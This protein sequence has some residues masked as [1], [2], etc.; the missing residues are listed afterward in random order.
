MIGSRFPQNRSR[1]SSTRGIALVSILLLIAMISALVVL[2]LR[3]TN[4]KRW[5]AGRDRSQA[6]L[7]LLAR[8]ATEIIHLRLKQR[9]NPGMYRDDGTSKSIEELRRM[10]EFSDEGTDALDYCPPD[11]PGNCFHGYRFQQGKD[12]KT[13]LG[14]YVRD[15]LKEASHT[16][17]GVPDPVG[18]FEPCLESN[19]CAANEN[20]QWKVRYIGDHDLDPLYPATGH[21]VPIPLHAGFDFRNDGQDDEAYQLLVE[22]EAFDGK[23]GTRSVIQ[24]DYL[25]VAPFPSVDAMFSSSANV[26]SPMNFHS[27]YVKG[28]LGHFPDSRNLMDFYSGKPWVDL[29][30]FDFGEKGVLHPACKEYGHN[31]MTGG[32]AKYPCNSLF[33]SG[34]R[35]AD[36]ERPIFYAHM[37][38]KG[39]ITNLGIGYGTFYSGGGGGMSFDDG[40]A[41]TGD[42]SSIEETREVDADALLFRDPSTFA[43]PEDMILGRNEDGTISDFSFLTDLATMRNNDVVPKVTS[44][45]GNCIYL[46][47]GSTDGGLST[48]V[49]A[50]PDGKTDQSVVLAPTSTCT[51]HIEGDYVFDGDL[52]W[53]GTGEGVVTGASGLL[54]SNLLVTGNVYILNNINVKVGPNGSEA[55]NQQWANYR[56]DNFSAANSSLTQEFDSLS[57]VAGGHVVIGNLANSNTYAHIMTNANSE[58]P[59]YNTDFDGDGLGDYLV[60]DGYRPGSTGRPTNDQ[61]QVRRHTCAEQLAAGLVSHC[62]TNAPGLLP[63]GSTLVENHLYKFG[64]LQDMFPFPDGGAGEDAGGFGYVR[65]PNDPANHV[66]PANPSADTPATANRPLTVQDP[67]HQSSLPVGANSDLFQGGWISTQKFREFANASIVSGDPLRQ[68][69]SF[70]PDYVNQA[71][72]IAAKLFAGGAVVGLASFDDKYNLPEDGSDNPDRMTGD[73]TVV[74]FTSYRDGGWGRLLT[75]RVNSTSRYPNRCTSIPGDVPYLNSDPFGDGKGIPR[76]IDVFGGIFAKYVNVL[77][78]NGLCM[79]SDDRPANPGHEDILV[80]QGSAYQEEAR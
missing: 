23:G 7:T 42:P 28:V 70:H 11:T 50:L 80:L 49:N 4:L 46:S 59:Y 65:N 43:M 30:Y 31:R 17:G 21:T 61:F 79:Y 73:P 64:F 33:S 14:R 55:Q 24:A 22:I 67:L 2:S 68:H 58:L 60:P 20:A 77:S 53:G 25:L 75:K 39:L 27:G 32:G 35:V 47:D 37:L 71:H 18:V 62:S 5:V 29:E 34:A 12:T 8:S 41:S 13:Q 36:H 54:D 52:V 19:G 45:G 26:L 74:K 16:R 57:L 63:E 48:P 69:D 51:I 56:N 3:S 78:T 10:V 15:F 40:D 66:D 6:N 1:L 72:F 9:M 76:G 38:S 44:S